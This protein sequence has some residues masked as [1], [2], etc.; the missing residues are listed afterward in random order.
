M[1][2]HRPVEKCQR[3]PSWRSQGRVPPRVSPVPTPL[4]SEPTPKTQAVASWVPGL[5]AGLGPALSI[6]SIP[7][8]L[9]SRPRPP[10]RCHQEPEN[11][12]PHA[13]RCSGPGRG[14]RGVREAPGPP[15]PLPLHP[16][17]SRRSPPFGT[18]ASRAQRGSS[19][20]PVSHSQ[21]PTGRAH[22]SRDRE[23]RGA[24]CHPDSCDAGAIP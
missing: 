14:P 20:R 8:P 2:F 22:K 10:R 3:V 16:H 12:G 6:L 7:G 19:I 1:A 13:G 4:P 23:G 5:P 15:S 9:A 11:W 24:S 21:D 17:S 18:E